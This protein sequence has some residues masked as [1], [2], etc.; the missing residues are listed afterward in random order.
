MNIFFQSDLS[1]GI[2]S[3]NEEESKHCLRVLR[4]KENDRINLIDGKG[5]FCE[6]V[7]VHA[8]AKRCEYEIIERIPEYNK[9]NFNLTIAI[10][11]TKNNER[12]EWFLE[13]ATE[14]GIDQ[15]IPIVCRYSERKDIKT[16]R[17]EKIIISAVKQSQKAYIPKL[18]PVIKFEEFIKT[19]FPGDKFIAHCF[20]EEKQ[21]LK[22]IAR[23]GTD[24]LIC[25]GPEG[26]FSPHEVEMALNKGFK[27][28]SLGNS[29]LRTET[30]GL[31][32]CHTLNLLNE[33]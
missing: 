3:L 11:P 7:I 21:L 32:A 16:D 26:D 14:I 28:V 15:I 5:T 29:R 24:S 23:A 31:V 20:N 4:L 18:E 19:P 1:T 22:N 6:A 13:K 9:R 33:K 25:I 8:D 10:A 2:N 30:A 27:P 12:F 17:L